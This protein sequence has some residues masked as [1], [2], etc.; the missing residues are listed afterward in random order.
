MENFDCRG[1]SVCEDDA[2]ETEDT[3]SSSAKLS[4]AMNNLSER[5]KQISNIA[6]NLQ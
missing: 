6:E 2:A 1:C 5:S 3:A 4:T